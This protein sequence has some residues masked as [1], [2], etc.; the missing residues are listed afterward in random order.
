MARDKHAPAAAD[1]EDPALQSEVRAFAASLGLSGGGGGFA[2]DDFA[3]P[4]AAKR[5][6]A[7]KEQDKG[8][9][10]ADDRE[11][12][13]EGKQSQQQ[14]QQ[15]QQQRQPPPTAKGEGGSVRPPRTPPDEGTGG[16]GGGGN[17]SGAR[18]PIRERGWNSG[19]G[20]RPAF[21]APSAGGAAGARSILPKDDP[22]VWH[23]A[24]LPAL[25][26]PP[27]ALARAAA[28]A[29]AAAARPSSAPDP[30]DPTLDAKRRKE[31]RRLERRR[32]K[33]AAA[34][35]AAAAAAATAGD[36]GGG[37][38]GIG[39]APPPLE[40]DGDT[41]ERLRQRADTL[42][43]AEAAAY[44]QAL[45]RRSAGD[46]RWLQ[47]VRRSGTTAD[48]VAAMTL[49]VQVRSSFL[50]FCFPVFRLLF[51]RSRRGRRKKEI[52]RRARGA[53]AKP[54]PRRTPFSRPNQKGAHT[55][56]R[57]A[58]IHFPAKG[59][60][61]INTCRHPN[62]GVARL[63]RQRALFSRR[64]R[65]RRALARTNVPPPASLSP[66]LRRSDPAL[67][68]ACGL[69]RPIFPLTGLKPDGPT[70]NQLQTD[71]HKSQK[72]KTTTIHITKPQKITIDK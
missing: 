28:A 65:R 26:P 54:Q 51:V 36:G 72:Q 49:L 32:Q 15:K 10:R 12:R 4:P 38:G 5:R 63:N 60:A 14:Q 7:D 43:E 20:P 70:Q 2:F 42:L 8:D 11:R 37:G 41:V 47:Q 25:V 69:S 6:G 58:G 68:A 45:G 67:P 9:E 13:G 30:D 31:L 16:G 57:R 1:Q 71:P 64:C 29:A 56:A 59:A 50:C 23:E 61:R 62:G 21:F 33:Q 18:D 34:G 27:A 48:R 52:E 44:E 24:A 53:A 40:L 17:G 22:A 39:G 66:P 19:A 3:P 35:G 46:A 55:L